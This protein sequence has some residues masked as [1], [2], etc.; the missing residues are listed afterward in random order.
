MHQ[1]KGDDSYKGNI[2]NGTANSETIKIDRVEE[3]ES[4]IAVYF[5]AQGY[6]I[7]LFLESQEDGSLKGN[8]FDMFDAKGVRIKK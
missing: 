2:S 6:D 4:A 1:E 5:W 8:M 3:K 7:C